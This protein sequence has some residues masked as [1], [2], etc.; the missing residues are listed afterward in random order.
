MADG[1]ERPGRGISKGM[2]E[3][4]EDWEISTKITRYTVVDSEGQYRTEY[5]ACGCLCVCEQ[6][7]LGV[8]WCE[9]GFS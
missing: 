7:C 5:R 2:R 4:R 3:E 6:V 9:Q 1:D 8:C